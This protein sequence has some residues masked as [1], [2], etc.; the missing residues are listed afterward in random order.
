MVASSASPSGFSYAQA[1]KGRSPVT[2]T[3]VPTPSASSNA[4]NGAAS[5]AIDSF[6]ELKPGGNWADDV[7]ATVAGKEQAEIPKPAEDVAKSVAS[8]KES[9]VARAKSEEKTETSGVSSPDLTMSGSATTKDDDSSRAPTHGS[10]S[11]T[12]WETKSQEASEP[13]WIAD[14]KERQASSQKSDN[15]VKGENKSTELALPSPPKPALQEAPLPPVNIWLKRAE[16]QKVKTVIPQPSPSKATADAPAT[17]P[18]AAKENQRP[19][20]D[21]RKKAMSVGNI[22]R[23]GEAP[24]STNS[25]P[26]KPTKGVSDVRVTDLSRVPQSAAVTATT[27]T[28]RMNAQT[29]SS[30]P[31]IPNA[32]SFAKE[33]GS[34]PTPEVA[35]DNERKDVTDKESAEKPS[36]EATPSSKGRKKHEW[37]KMVVTP[38]IRWEAQNARGADGQRPPGAER[39]GRGG[40]M[41]GR[42]SFRGGASGGP[43]GSA[44]PAQRGSVSLGD[45]EVSPTWAQQRGRTDMDDRQAM[46][47]PPKPNRASSESSRREQKTEPPRDRSV[48]GQSSN[49]AQP[50]TDGENLASR[51]GEGSAATSTWVDTQS[52]LP[53]TKS[54]SHINSA[55]NEGKEEIR[56]PEPTPRRSSVGTQTDNPPRSGPPP[57]RMVASDPRKEQRSFDS[58]KDT[59]MNGMSRG[60]GKRGGRG[61]GGAREFTANGHQPGHAYQNGE[62]ASSPGYGVPP[63]PSAYHS[64]RGHHVAY[65]GRGGFS[66]GNPR[67]HSIPESYYGRYNNNAYGPSQPPPG[68]AYTPG[69]YD[70]NGYPMSA[71]PYQPYMDHQ[72][73]MAMVNLQ[74]EYYFSIDNLLKDMFLRKNM[75]SQGFVF[76]DLVASFNRIKQLTQDR[77]LLKEVCLA[78]ETIEIRVGEDGKERLRRHDGYEQFLLP[79]EQRD[80]AAQNDGPKQL[81]PPE[82]SHLPAFGAMPGRGLAN[83]GFPGMQPRYDRRSYDGGFPAMNGGPPQFTAFAGVPEAQPYAEMTNGED[84]RGRAEKSP[85]Q[86]GQTPP[87]PQPVPN[88]EKDAEPDAFPDDQVTI[89]TVMVRVKKDPPFFS[90]ATRTFSNGSIDS[91]SIFAEL[92]KAKEPQA[93]STPNGDNTAA[94]GDS[95]AQVAESNKPRSAKRTPASEIYWAKEQV[96]EPESLPSDITSEPYTRLHYKALEQRH[97]ATLGTCPYDLDVLYKF[98]SHFLLRNFNAKMYSEFHHYA[99]EDR[100]IRQS[101]NGLSALIK[102]YD[103]ALHSHSTIRDRVVRDYVEL[104][105]HEPAGLE[106]AAF[107]QL[108]A[109]WRDGALNLKNRKK[110]VD[111][112]GTV[113]KGRLEGAGVSP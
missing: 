91:R 68:Q 52:N 22:P 17:R 29:R 101:L 103:Q 9:S 26:R 35:Q 8:S 49:D 38:T 88:T 1:A 12:T 34:W 72:Y 77:S 106:A 69:M 64:S 111:V 41:R 100:K 32:P 63:S 58:Y 46:P 18:A 16:A 87:M 31:N 97:H 108:R 39:G 44:R 107:R 10:S 59:N 86:D 74:L 96:A 36:D 70:Y 27:P 45:E 105:E 25:E 19:R 112:V 65:P 30:L 90:E 102:F 78:S 94:N 83:A 104:V 15:T 93:A 13:A 95:P 51:Q 75:D 21:S 33:R 53:R 5:P 24:Y 57:I 73:L 79:I 110:L 4:I 48:K 62:V 66:R 89:L 84:T 40:T 11:D 50:Q 56:F 37:E 14:R 81:Q 82:R 85:T 28:A 23:T 2:S 71:M 47:P 60:A 7:E 43:N 6:S 80:P 113:L 54:P 92:E 61:R 109:A 98:W 55:A 42:G 76:L 67:A 3:T 20:A 99:N